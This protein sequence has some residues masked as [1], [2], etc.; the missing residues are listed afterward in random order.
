MD[1]I[2]ILDNFISPEDCAL[3]INFYNE[4]KESN[5][6]YSTEDGRFLKL[7]PDYETSNYL[8]DK[9]IP[10]IN[11]VYETNFYIR[12]VLLSYYL[13]SSSLKPHIDSAKESLKD[14]LGVLFYFN[15]NFEGG[16]LYFT[17]F[18]FS[19][20][21]KAGSVIVFPCNSSEYKHGVTA[22]TS[23]IRYAMPVEIT[24]NQE[25]SWR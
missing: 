20:K 13:P 21:P 1:K 22:I 9:Y 11:E 25:L 10:K 24:R 3:A 17:K 2:K 5:S 12:E 19:Y 6:L 14:S 15:D 8:L 18:D 7:N 4:L 16:E 23:G